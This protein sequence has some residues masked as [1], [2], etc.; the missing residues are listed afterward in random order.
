MRDRVINDKV[1][2]EVWQSKGQDG[3]GFKNCKNYNN[4]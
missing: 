1:V 3:F 4:Q 2:N